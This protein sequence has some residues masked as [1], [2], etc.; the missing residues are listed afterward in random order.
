LLIRIVSEQKRTAFYA[1]VG[2]ATSFFALGLA[3]LW[4][5]HPDDDAF[6]LFRYAR[7]VAH[8]DGIVFNVPG[9]HAE[10][11][12]DFLWML[13][14][15]GLT[16][17]GLDLA[18][19]ALFLNTLGAAL[20]A[21]VLC[22]TLNT[23]LMKPARRASWVVLVIA[24]VTLLSAATAAY[25]GFSS[26]L[27]AALGLAVLHASLEADKLAIAWVPLAALVL[28]LFRPDGV[29][30]GA[31]IV[32]VGALRARDLGRVRP[33]ATTACAAGALAVGYYMW[34]SRYFGLPLPLPLY[35]KSRTGDVE[36]LASMREPLKS[37]LTRLP[38]LGANL[39]WVLVGGAIGALAVIALAAHLLHRHVAVETRLRLAIAFLPLAA[40]WGSLCFAYQ[41][42]NIDW[43]FQSMIQLGA[44][45]FA[46]RGVSALLRRRLASEN[47]A[48]GLLGAI[49]LPAIAA[50]VPRVEGRLRGGYGDFVNVF[51][52]SS[53]PVRT[54]L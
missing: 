33:Y 10:G 45:Y 50:G 6:I 18:I 40:L 34:R 20:T 43:R 7:N 52:A 14:L 32:V 53:M 25:G 46:V 11:A 5:G 2:G 16:A 51:A 42:Q 8:G 54:S 9:P 12:T 29:F 30:V 48:W 27:Y 21:Y 15:S 47:V 1:A 22:R 37:L 36:K 35:V 44:I 19:A 31:A 26:M 17:L 38:G 41:S 28:G 39:H 23:S 24:C 4:T 49:T 13:G 3:S